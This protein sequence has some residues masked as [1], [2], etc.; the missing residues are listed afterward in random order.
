VTQNNKK[1]ALGT[2]QFGL[3]YG[4]SNTSGQVSLQEAFAI[5][6]LA[7]AEN[8]DLYDTAPAYGNSEEVVGQIA[9]LD[10]L[11][12]TKT[13]S[14]TNPE[15]KQKDINYIE[16]VFQESLVQFKRDKVYGLL[17]HSIEDLKKTGNK[18]LLNW[19]FEKKQQG[20]VDKI[21]VSVYTAEDIDYVLGQFD[22]DI[23]QLPI[24]VLDQRLILSGH[25]DKL[26]KMDVE[27]H[28]R[29]IFLQGL[30]LMD[31]VDI[32]AYFEVYKHEFRKFHDCVSETG[33]T[34]LQISLGFVL[35]LKEIDR[36]IIGVNSE[37]QL[38][39]IIE[40]SKVN[41]TDIKWNEMNSND[42]SLLN[43]AKWVI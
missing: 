41:V 24:N 15:I 33:L 4:I 42:P 1:L 31:P 2:V 26:K 12:V 14:I 38:E 36:V 30:L 17:V 11:L 18:L 10:S 25:L 9:S 43:P 7:A 19:L 35:N 16:S 5:S 23:I 20:L 40:A 22:V 13:Q 21:G 8:V 39:Q 29:S 28:A 37:Q 27:I 34:P 6:K 3:D 32:P